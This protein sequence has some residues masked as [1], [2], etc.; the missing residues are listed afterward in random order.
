MNNLDNL[1]TS[2]QQI[3]RDTMH[4]FGKQLHLFQEGC[5]L[6]MDASDI[7]VDTEKKADHHTAEGASKSAAW[8]FI[9]T[10]HTSLFW[11][12]ETALNGDYAI[13]KNILR[14]SLEEMIKLEYYVAFPDMALKQVEQ[15]SDKD[16]VNLAQMLRELDFEDRQNLLKVYGNLS[17]LYAHANFNLPP[18]LVFHELDNQTRIGGGPRFSPDF[19]DPIIHHLIAIV[20]NS[21]RC[22]VIRF[23]YLADNQTW[24]NQLENF[25][26]RVTGIYPD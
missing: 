15:D 25:G 23:P 7:L 21:L 10:L 3:Y 20:A 22:V 18:E 12:C 4:Q 24:M 26:A 16:E 9:S 6:L 1:K 5:L 19:F 8:R 11:C 17:A 13:S 14:L 2:R